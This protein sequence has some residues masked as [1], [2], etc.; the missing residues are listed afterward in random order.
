MRWARCAGLNRL[1]RPII[2]FG[3]LR[4]LPAVMIW[5]EGAAIAFAALS[6]ASYWAL[7]TI[8]I[9]FNF[10]ERM[11]LKVQGF[12][13]S[14]QLAA[15]RAPKVIANI[16]RLCNASRPPAKPLTAAQTSPLNWLRACPRRK[17]QRCEIGP[18]G[19]GRSQILG[20]CLHVLKFFTIE[21]EQVHL[22]ILV[23]H[24]QFIV[25]TGDRQH[26]GAL[27]KG[28][29]FRENCDRALQ[30]DDKHCKDRYETDNH[31]GCERCDQPPQKLQI[32][33]FSWI[34]R[35]LRLICHD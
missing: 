31:G 22:A 14:L 11:Q 5:S 12:Y 18:K 30:A 4:V 34:Y 8:I 13:K 7:V 6:L 26:L 29:D 27:R 9:R 19:E 28:C 16:E 20:Q 1:V 10:G 17:M 2:T 3:F 35:N 23:D 24:D 25:C 32:R 15:D 33:R 21:T